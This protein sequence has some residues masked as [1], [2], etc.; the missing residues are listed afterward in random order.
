[1][2]IVVKDLPEI[3]AADITSFLDNYVILVAPFFK[4]FKRLSI[5]EIK[6]L[7]SLR[8]RG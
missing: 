5:A 6:L 4:D 1:M 2:D 3:R 8:V 7:I